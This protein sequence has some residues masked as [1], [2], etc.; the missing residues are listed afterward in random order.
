ML[1]RL[2]SLG[3]RGIER[4]ELTRNRSVMVSFTATRIRVHHAYVDAPD[5]VLRAIVEFVDSRTRAGRR[6][7]RARLLQ[8]NVEVDAGP[9]R[10]ESTHPA[11]AGLAARL[12][13]EHARLNAAM[14]GESLRPLTVRVSRRMRARLGH[15]VPAGTNGEPAEIGISRRHVLR[16]GFDEALETLLHEMIHQ[17]Q[18]ERGLGLDHGPTFRAKARELGISPFARRTVAA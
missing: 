4:C 8:F 3:L 14:F 12:T 18:D 6:R 7:A 16:H 1:E 2:R 5:D 11:D 15:Y 9:R 17:W 13:R 10:R